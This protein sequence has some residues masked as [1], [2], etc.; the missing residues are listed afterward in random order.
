MN[1]SQRSAGVRGRTEQATPRRPLALISL[2]LS[3]VFPLA[4]LLNVVGAL[5]VA[6][7]VG[8]LAGAFLLGAALTPL[9]VPC[10][11]L[12][13]AT[14]HLALSRARRD[15]RAPSERWM[16]LVSLALGYA[17]LAF[18]IG[19]IALFLIAGVHIV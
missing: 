9:G 10:F 6:N 8:A 12:A 16:A 4:L 13:I 15:P 3:V 7:H 19:N 17:S 14:G 1:A 5:G 11:I 18:F 2:L